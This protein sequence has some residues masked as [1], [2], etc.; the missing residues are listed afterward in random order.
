MVAFYWLFAWY[1]TLEFYWVPELVLS[2]CS[3]GAAPSSFGFLSNLL[4]TTGLP[5]THIFFHRLPLHDQPSPDQRLFFQA[6]NEHFYFLSTDPCY[7][8]DMHLEHR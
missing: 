1:A 2:A 7:Y 4:G 3:L 8:D 5:T 6:E